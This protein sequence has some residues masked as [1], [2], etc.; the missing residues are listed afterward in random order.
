[1]FPQTFTMFSLNPFQTNTLSDFNTKHKHT[2]TNQSLVAYSLAF[3]VFFALI[4]SRGFEVSIQ[5]CLMNEVLTSIKA[6]VL[7]Q[8]HQLRDWPMLIK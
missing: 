5:C 4:V 3:F 6:S 2:H 7:Q 1:M 8:G